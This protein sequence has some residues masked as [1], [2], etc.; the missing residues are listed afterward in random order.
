MASA[1]MM[2]FAPLPRSTP[3]RTVARPRSTLSATY[4]TRRL[5][6][7]ARSTRC[8]PTF[9]RALWPPCRRLPSPPFFQATGLL[10]AARCQRRPTYVSH[11]YPATLLRMPFDARSPALIS[12][13]GPM[14]DFILSTAL[15]HAETRPAGFMR[16]GQAIQPNPFGRTARSLRSRRS[17]CLQT[18]SSRSVLRLSSA[19]LAIM[20]LFRRTALLRTTSSRS[21]RQLRLF[22]WTM[23]LR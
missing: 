7:T 22:G 16:H 5:H 6:L 19:M 11:T 2:R 1:E 14:L 20:E 13:R 8:L 23:A 12:G 10:C 3:L 17:L 15:A 9:Q 21:R 4:T 18:S